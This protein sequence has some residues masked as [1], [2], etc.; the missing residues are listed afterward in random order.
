MKMNKVPKMM[1]ITE[2]RR[3]SRQAL[4]ELLSE[5]DIVILRRNKAVAVL[6]SYQRW[7]Q[8]KTAINII[9]AI[10]GTSGNE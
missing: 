4:V 9:K 1:S 7:V 5:D 3:L 10:G 2:V 8:R 6:M